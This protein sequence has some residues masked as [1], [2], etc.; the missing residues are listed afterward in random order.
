MTTHEKSERRGGLAAFIRDYRPTEN[1]ADELL[2]PAGAM[3]PAWRDFINQFGRL[4]G[5]DIERRFH[6]AEQYLHDAGV[7]YREYDH[8]FSR[9]RAWPL[10]HIPVLLS[11]ED[12]TSISEALVQRADL[13]EQILAD[14]YGPNHL[15][16]DGH[17]PASLVA[18]M[19]EW[20]R[21]MVGVEPR[22]GHFLHFIAFE[23]GRGP[24]GRWWVLGDRTQ[25]P[26]GA[27]FAVENRVAMSRMFPEYFADKTVAKIGGF[28]AD[29][30]AALERLSD[31]TEGGVGVL[32]P[33]MLNQGYF[34]HAYIARYL[35]FMLL[36]GEDLV[37]RDGRVMVRTVNGL[38]PISVIWR[39]ID[40]AWADPLELNEA[41][42]LG[43]PGMANAVRQGSLTMVN[44]LGSGVLE[45]RAMLAFIPRICQALTG[46]PLKMPNIATWWC[47][48]G[49]E[50]SHVQAN[51]ERMMIAPALATRLPFDTDGKTVLGGRFRGTAKEPI[52]DWIDAEA[53]N[54]VGQEAVR[55][56]TTPAWDGEKLVPRPMSLRVFAARTKKG[57][58]LMPGGYARIGRH[59]ESTAISLQKGGSV[60]DVWLLADPPGSQTAIAE[61]RTV[62]G[63]RPDLSLLPSRAADNLY[64][65]GRYVER[66]EGT[67]RLLR[68]YHVR[69]AENAAADMPLQHAIGEALTISGVDVAQ[70]VPLALTDMLDAAVQ[71]AAQ[72]R[73]RFSVD[74]WLALKELQAAAMLLAE[75]HRSDDE[76]RSGDDIARE[77]SGLLRQITGFSGLVQDNMYR[78]TG[79]RFLSIGRALERAMDI[80][81]MLARFADHG[82]PEGGLDLAVELGD[83]GITHRRRYTIATNRQTV[84]DLLA[85]DGRNPRALLYQL[86][87]MR[88][89]C[90]RLPG[91]DEH[92]RLADFYRA[93]IRVQTDI[94]LQ[95]PHT[96]DTKALWKTRGEL[97]EVSNLLTQHY[98]R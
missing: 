69:L 18:S 28:F 73:D 45:T 66:A 91:A 80:C 58:A 62:L 56:S 26:T 50:R 6:R 61:A 3:R 55:L 54:L 23:I 65:L 14:L 19:P 96:L 37:V 47:G 67:M 34:E 71:S 90:E 87:R 17:L 77:I 13:L 36:E 49:A 35:G 74:G 46:E 81:A 20:L 43:T 10:S 11:E 21:P 98:F 97:M 63:T 15:V 85:L 4:S 60:A 70:P 84:I 93:V 57:W 52:G 2:D 59:Q 22:S 83:S 42:R 12:W 72:V 7:Y 38:Q 64:W 33:G 32:T 53:G 9:E 88:T 94:E 41:S 75:N 25:A 86:N 16:A 8:G 79:W 30:R 76:P 40:A 5:T 31:E 95:R 48:Q 82:T 44:A 27:G 1:T 78:F 24:D 51:T 89:L 39:R 29:F 68:A 92:G